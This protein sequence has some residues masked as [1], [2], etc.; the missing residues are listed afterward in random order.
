MT[1]DLFRLLISLLFCYFDVCYGY[2]I[3]GGQNRRNFLF[4]VTSNAA[5]PGALL[6]T[7]PQ[8]AQAVA[9][10]ITLGE[11]QNLGA[12]TLRRFRPK[13]P[14]ILRQKLNLDF[15]VSL[16][17][18]SYAVTDEL[19]IVPMD[20]FQRDFFLIRSAEYEP[21]V[22]DLGPGLVSQGDL[23]DP[24]YFDFISFA[25]YLTINRILINDP[26]VVFEEQQAINKG[27]DVPNEFV[28][29]IVR[30]DPSIT[31][32]RLLSEH[33]ER[34]GKKILDKLNETFGDSPSSLPK[35]LNGSRPGADEI[36]ASLSQ[37]IKL[38]LINGYAF[39]GVAEVKIASAIP[40]SASG[41][42]FSLTLQSPATLW[43]GKALAF[44]KSPLRNDYLL[45]TSIA[46]AQ[47]L[48]YRV[49]SSSVK[50]EGNSEISLLTLQ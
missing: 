33:N 7:N 24:Y 10:P 29:V 27:D 11:T 47:D 46:L 44:Q 34:V 31:N 14:R 50:Y 5:L 4:R 28:K 41:A 13:P 35:F 45:K 40:G 49:V 1:K 12:Q 43:G 18:S 38:F 22:N 42:T 17:R 25:Q 26:P 32:D 39:D 6:L 19:D 36:M 21:Y 16:M 30:R 8:A 20:Q 3:P 37:L 15:A 48:G 9:A 23:T 2:D